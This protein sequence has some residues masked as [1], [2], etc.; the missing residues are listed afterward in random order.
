MERDEYARMHA[1]ERGYWWFRAKRAVVRAL[2]SRVG[3]GEPGPADRVVDVGCGTGAVLEAFGGRG[4]AVGIDDHAEALA[5]ARERSGAA[6]VRGSVT[7]LPL[8][9][10]SVDRLFL[11]D[12]AEHVEDD[13][14]AFAEVARALAPGGL[15]VVHVPAHPALWSPHDEALHHVRRY[16]RDEL[17]DRLAAAGL[18]P[19]AT[20]W[21]FAAILA[22]AAVLRRLRRGG[23]TDFGVVPRW[24]DGPLALWHRLEAAWLERFDLPFG[25][26]LA[27]V[28]RRDEAAS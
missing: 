27:A 5:H 12:V 15:A 28:V 20:T 16:R 6:L 24:L 22:P 1:L 19:L 8:A 17:L 23:G 10:G 21:T 18:E 3:A 11:L 9:S 14:A 7:A 26:S 25:L 2:L 13:R 4:R